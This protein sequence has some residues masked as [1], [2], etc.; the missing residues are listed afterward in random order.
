MGR[1]TSR[2]SRVRPEAASVNVT[3]NVGADGMPLNLNKLLDD[4]VEQV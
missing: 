2:Q 3:F 4:A 1:I